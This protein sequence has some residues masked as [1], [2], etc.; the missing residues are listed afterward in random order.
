[1][2]YQT[3]PVP[4]LFNE[5]AQWIRDTDEHAEHH[6]ELL[7]EAEQFRLRGEVPAP[8][9]RR[10]AVRLERWR[11]RH[12]HQHASELTSKDQAL[13]DT[14]DRTARRLR[15]HPDMP[16]R[17][18]RHAIQDS[19]LDSGILRKATA[20]CDDGTCLTSLIDWAREL[21]DQHFRVPASGG[22]AAHR[23]MLLY[24]PLYVSSH[25][26]NY[27]TYCGFR[28]PLSIP[29]RHL[30]REQALH[31]ARI[32]GRRGLKHILV[33]GGDFPSRTTTSY[34]RDILADL[35]REGFCPAIEIAPQPTESYAELVHAGARG[36]TLYQETY[37]QSRYASYHARGPKSSFHWRLEA[38]DRAAEAGM[39][40]LGLGVLLGLSDP[41]H[42]LRALMRHGAYLQER[43][44]GRTLAF[45]LPRIHE[46]PDGFAIPFPVAD[47][48]LIRWYCLLRIA[49]PRAE[50][51]LSTREPPELRNRLTEICVTQMSAGSSTIP[52]GYQLDP[53]GNGEQFPVCDQRAVGEVTHWL[54]Q[55]G[56]Q[57]AWLPD[58]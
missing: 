45:S 43:F 17:G 51:V 52:G 38:H 35:V 30:S 57:V 14:L 6:L 31:E 33:V 3:E 10:L 21:T 44:S 5:F 16:P 18:T 9:A 46:A 41:K 26:V 40:R 2:Q 20:L 11:Y 22:S 27:C 37:D 56:Y 42:D 36:L 24:A 12:L 32:L 15:G 25:C 55:A 13:V 28:Y 53:H 7:G 34:F 54:E 29:R 47:E 58:G 49:F 50:L 1:M 48:Q 4:D 39:R 19:T 23:R 8:D